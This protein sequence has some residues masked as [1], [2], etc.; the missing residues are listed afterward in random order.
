MAT[1]RKGFIRSLLGF[2][3]PK[4]KLVDDAADISSIPPPL[5]QKR[6]SIFRGP[7]FTMPRSVAKAKR[8]A[9]KAAR[10]INRRRAA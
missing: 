4:R 6:W 7:N 8:K 3:K 2:L 10:R 5:P 9:A 1:E